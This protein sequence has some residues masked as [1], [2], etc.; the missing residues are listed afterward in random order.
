M[1]IQSVRR[2]GRYTNHVLKTKHGLVVD[3]GLL[4]PA[5]RNIFGVLTSHDERGRVAARRLIPASNIVT[6]EGDQFY[7]ELLERG[8]AGA[9]TPAP[10]RTFN[11]L[12]LISARTAVWAKTGAASQYGNGTI[13]GAAKA[14]DA[15]YPLQNDTD[16]DN[17]DRAVDVLSYRVSFTTAEVNGTIVGGMIH[18][19]SLTVATSPLLSGFDITS[20]TKT[21]SDTLKFFV[22]HNVTGS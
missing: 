18:D 7:A 19:S 9:A 20:F 16:T 2:L 8:F 1:L 22:N 10:T 3:G 13:V 6:D 15:T 5:H 11:R 21:S 4:V 12:A 14:F 17:A